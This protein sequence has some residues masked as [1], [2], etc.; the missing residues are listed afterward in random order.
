MA[1]VDSETV[2][3]R[4]HA[5]LRPA[6]TGLAADDDDCGVCSGAKSML[7]AAFGRYGPTAKIVAAATATGKTKQKLNCCH[8]YQQ[9]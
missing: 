8:L 6:R 1:A 2:S 3:D 7:R 5:K 4:K 9:S